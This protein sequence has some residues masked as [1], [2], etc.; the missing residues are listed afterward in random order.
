MNSITD[1]NGTTYVYDH[2]GKIKSY[3][4]KHGIIYNET[5]IKISSFQIK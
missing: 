1:H 3:R 5:G 4:D 2:N